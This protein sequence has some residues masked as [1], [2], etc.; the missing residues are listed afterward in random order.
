MINSL[1][2]D[3][4]KGARFVIRDLVAKHFK[5]IEIVGEADG[6]ESG[7]EAI[8]KHKPDFIFLDIQMRTGTGFDLLEKIKEINFEVI[9]VTAYNEY[10]L[11]AF[12]FSAFGYLLKPIKTQDFCDVV[13]K[14]EANLLSSK[15]DLNKRL[16]VLV[17][18]YGDGGKVQKL[19]IPNIE[20]FQIV[21][22]ATIIRLEGDG[23]Y[24]H[25]VTTEN[26]KITATKNIG[27]YEKLLNNYGFFRIHQSTIINLSYVEKYLKEDGGK[28]E[29]I[30]GVS[31]KISRYRKSAFLNRFD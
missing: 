27:E 23:N 11:D 16:K 15:K 21:K 31:L 5:G 4:E 2:I 3:D 29:M 8:Y 20:G 10:A 1:I 12:K 28:V 26:K 17:E 7:I 30:D 25:F 18:N 24:T 9:F 22:I 13:G 14:L 19:V 6:V